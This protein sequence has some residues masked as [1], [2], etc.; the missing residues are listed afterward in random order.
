[1]FILG[2]CEFGIGLSVYTFWFLFPKV[3]AF[4]CAPLALLAGG[5]GMWATT[6][7]WVIAACVL[8][9]FSVVCGLAGAITDGIASAIWVSPAICAQYSNP[10][11]NGGSASYTFYGDT[12][13]DSLMFE[14][15]LWMAFNLFPDPA[16]CYCITKS[17]AAQSYAMASSQTN[18]CADV[19]NKWMLNL[20]ASCVLCSLIC[21][22][23]FVLAVISCVDLCRKSEG[24]QGVQVIQT[25]GQPIAKVEMM[26]QYAQH[27]Y[28][29]Q[30]YPQQQYAQQQQY[31]PQ[32][33]YPQQQYAQQ[34]QYPPQQQ[35][36]S[37]DQTYAHNHDQHVGRGS[38]HTMTALRNSGSMRLS[39]H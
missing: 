9:S 31:P 11:T 23:S 30:P 26:Q 4:W 27:P 8:A 29:Q 20:S 16:L 7:S 33:P 25:V 39:G 37:L 18:T 17:A 6:R 3:G 5:S 32:Q 15:G 22:G 36:P 10:T 38:E 1:M 24:V 34:Q 2:M 19:R 21:I 28:P 14:L 35:H 12:T 13:D